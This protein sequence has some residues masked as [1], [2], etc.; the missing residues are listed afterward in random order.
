MK[1]KRHHEDF[2]VSSLTTKI[3]KSSKKKQTKKTMNQIQNNFLKAHITI[4]LQDFMIS[5]QIKNN[6]NILL[7]GIW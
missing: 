3:I 2:T 5:P 4:Q 1:T 6:L 7:A